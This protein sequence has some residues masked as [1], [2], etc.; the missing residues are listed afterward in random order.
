MAGLKNSARFTSR[1]FQ[2]ATFQEVELAWARAQRSGPNIWLAVIKLEAQRTRFSK[3]SEKARAWIL[4]SF[5]NKSSGS[6]QALEK[7]W[8]A[9]ACLCLTLKARARLRL[10]NFTSFGTRP[11]CQ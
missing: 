7:I 3:S 2:N 11:S 1:V 9:Q 6:K 8:Q 10:E 5:K 4:I